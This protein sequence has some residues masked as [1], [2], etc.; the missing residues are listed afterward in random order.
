MSQPPERGAPPPGRWPWQRTLLNR[1]IFT[2]GLI[3]LAILALLM[4]YVGRAVY[5]VQLD[6]IEHALEVEA[7]LVA[8]ALEDPLSGYAVEFEE[9]ERYEQE[10]EAESHQNSDEEDEYESDGHE[11]DDHES[12]DHEDDSDVSSVNRST[13]AQS[14]TLTAPTALR[15]QQLA[16]WYAQ[17]TGAR[18]SILEIGGDVIADSAV[19]PL[20]VGNQLHQIEVQAALTGK[21]QHAVRIDPLTGEETLYAAAPIW[22]GDHPLGVVRLAASVSEIRAP[23]RRLLRDLTLAALLALA[24]AVVTSIGV[25][26]RVVQP[27][28]RL[29]EAA[30]AVSE[31]NLTHSVPVETTDELGAL[32]I[33]FNTM[34]RQLSRL[35]EQQRMFIANASH[36]LRTPL[37]N[38]KLRSEALQSMHL[39]DDPTGR[40]YLAEID[41]EADRLARMANVLLDLSRLDAGH[42]T[43]PDKPTDIAPLLLALAQGFHVRMRGAGLTFIVQVPETLPPVPIWPQDLE[44]IVSNLLDNAIKYTLAGGT[45]HLTASADDAFCRIVV[46]DT[47]I[48]IPSEELPLIFDRFYRV[49]KARSRKAG[50]GDEAGSGAGLGL[51]IVKTLVEQNGGR[52]SALQHEDGSRF[53]VE[54]PVNANA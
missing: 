23:G 47:G 44:E 52:I 10:H 49:D 4:L 46:G 21:E 53:V 7:F 35:M 54:F 38:I 32:A 34:T 26:R 12:D 45:I 3:F 18:V 41:S 51:A 42:R 39:T 50:P 25:A 20:E 40:R 6:Q 43:P 9:Y 16:Q 24:V 1:L 28:R 8:N 30:L 48:G 14:T 19:P 29:E 31:G 37:T 33:A 15:L 5:R 13:P 11:S 2:Y 36:E 27:V 17:D 22:Q